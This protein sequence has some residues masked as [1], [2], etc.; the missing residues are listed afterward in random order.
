MRK[1]WTS[2]GKLQSKVPEGTLARKDIS[3]AASPSN[4]THCLEWLHAVEAATLL[5]GK[6]LLESCA[7]TCS[8]RAYQG[9]EFI[10]EPPHCRTGV[11]YLAVV[12]H[13]ALAMVGLIFKVPRPLVG[14]PHREPKWLDPKFLLF[15]S[16]LALFAS[17]LRLLASTLRRFASKFMQQQNGIHAAF[18]SK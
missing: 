9:A 14:F 3:G 1:P 16:R 11:L 8:T 13:R 17:T 6:H 7:K 5:L 15:T 2:Y 18:A 4:D 10:S 12:R